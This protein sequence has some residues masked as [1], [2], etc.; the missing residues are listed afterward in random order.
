MDYDGAVLLDY[1][2][3]LNLAIADAIA[4]GG[5]ALSSL[6]ILIQLLW[7]A[8]SM[9]RMQRLQ[10]RFFYQLSSVTKVAELLE[11][12][13]KIYRDVGVRVNDPHVEVARVVDTDLVSVNASRAHQ[14]DLFH[15][16]MVAMQLSLSKQQFLNLRTNLVAQFFFV[17]ELL[18]LLVAIVLGW[19]WIAY[20]AAVLG[21]GTILYT[22][23]R[24]EAFR[25]VQRDIL[26]FATD[27]LNLTSEEQ[28]LLRKLTM[29]YASHTGLYPYQSLRG[30]VMFILP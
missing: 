18:L 20:L 23:Y 27:L 15:T 5:F 1:T 8:W 14:T 13:V 6:V 28:E 2:N 16:G 25:S 24:Y 19:W 9:L 26:D 17:V 10:R 3:M 11:N 12:Y 29:H 4:I 22:W 30:I 21:I 7:L